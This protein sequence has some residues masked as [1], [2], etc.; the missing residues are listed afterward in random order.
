[1]TLIVTVSLLYSHYSS[2]YSYR[3][4]DLFRPLFLVFLS[5]A[6]FFRFLLFFSVLFIFS[7][8]IYIFSSISFTTSSSSSFL[9]LSLFFLHLLF[10]YLSTLPCYPILFL[11]LL[12]SLV[13]FVFCCLLVLGL[14]LRFLLHS[15][16]TSLSPPSSFSLNWAFRSRKSYGNRFILEKIPLTFLL[17]S[18]YS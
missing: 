4:P 18:L 8:N 14:H 16:F 17:L 13:F 1:M 12:H 6:S 11:F 3:R 10:I 9:V 5:P 2:S 7:S 15:H